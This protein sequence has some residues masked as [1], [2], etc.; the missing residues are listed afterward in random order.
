MYLL[1]NSHK[2]EEVKETI[3]QLAH[4]AM[5]TGAVKLSDLI[6]MLRQENLIEMQDTI[7]A[8]EQAQAQAQQ[9]AQ[10]QQAQLQEQAEQ[11]KESLKEKT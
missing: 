11:K 7:K 6:T 9:E 8:S 5:Q 4:A 2:P 3:R 1:L 10:A